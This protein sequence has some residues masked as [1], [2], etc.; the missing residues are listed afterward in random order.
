MSK[1]KAAVPKKL[2]PDARSKDRLGL[3]RLVSFSDAVFAIAL[4]SWYSTFACHQ[5]QIRLVTVNC[6]H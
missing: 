5:V 2:K 4:L 3:E 1:L 6:C